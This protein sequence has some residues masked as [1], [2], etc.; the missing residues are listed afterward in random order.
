MAH[1]MGC[2]LPYCSQ[3]ALP[4]ADGLPVAFS[5]SPARSPRPAAPPSSPTAGASESASAAHLHTNHSNQDAPATI[6]TQPGVL[7]Y[8]RPAAPQPPRRP[9][10]ATTTAAGP[11]T[12]RAI[13]YNWT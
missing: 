12:S 4:T 9:A 2:L 6:P 3:I 8:L 1:P 11:A 13:L 7:C 5:L 10:P